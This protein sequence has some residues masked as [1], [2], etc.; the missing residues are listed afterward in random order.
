MGPSLQILG[1]KGTYCSEE[2]EVV[3]AAGPEDSQLE[4]VGLDL[5]DSRPQEA[6]R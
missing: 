5:A 3:A 6:C 4:P 1:A 2:E